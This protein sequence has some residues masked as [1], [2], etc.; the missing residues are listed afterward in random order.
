MDLVIWLL[1]LVAILA[2]LVGYLGHKIS[3][4]RTIG[5]ADVQAR[6]ILDDAKRSVADATRE[7]EGKARDAEAK[8]RAAE[9]EAKEIALRTRADLEQESRSRQKEIQEIG[10]KYGMDIKA[11][12]S[13]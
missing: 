6:R 3:T 12:A 11:P 4:V 7:V 5:D 1:P 2:F 8:I 9:L 10:R 13:A